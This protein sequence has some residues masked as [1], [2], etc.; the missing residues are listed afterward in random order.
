[1]LAA[2]VV[3]GVLYVDGTAADNQRLRWTGRD[4]ACHFK[5]WS[6]APGQ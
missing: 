6:S 1:L 3:D 2:T 5:R 4:G